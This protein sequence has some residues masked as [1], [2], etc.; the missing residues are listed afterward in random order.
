MVVQ[1]WCG[2]LTA[3]AVTWDPCSFATLRVHCHVAACSRFTPQPYFLTR[4]VY[5]E[6]DMVLRRGVAQQP[7]A[8]VGRRHADIVP[9]AAR[10]HE[11]GARGR[12]RGAAP[13]VH[14]VSGFGV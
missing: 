6:D 13:P 7:P 10:R 4:D 2:L 8:K 1:L 11:H 12:A 14:G 3:V 9:C 5:V